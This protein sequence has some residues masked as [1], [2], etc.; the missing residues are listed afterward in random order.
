MNKR[1]LIVDDEPYNLMALK[2]ILGQAEKSLL[3]E[4]HGEDIMERTKGEICDIVDQATTGQ[5]AVDA[6]KKANQDQKF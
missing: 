4:I 1:I 6:I 2:I 3:T 5:E